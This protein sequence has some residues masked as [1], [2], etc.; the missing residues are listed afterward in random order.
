[1]RVVIAPD[2]FK[3]SMTS[4]DVCEAINVGLHKYKSSISVHSMP[5]ADGGEGTVD[6][7][8]RVMGGD[9]I[10]EEVN[11]PLGRKISSAY[12]WVPD[13]KT[14]I[15]ETAAASG[16]P[17]L[18]CNELNPLKA[19]TIGTGELIKFAL[20]RGAERIILG[21]GGSA[22]VDAGAGCFQALGVK[23]YN[24]IGEELNMNGK[25]LSQVADI[26]AT[27]FRQI[28][29]G[30]EWII[31]SDVSNPLLGERGA[32]H[33][34]GPQ[35]GVT[36]S[37]LKIFERGMENYANVMKNYTNKEVMDNRGSGAAGGFGFSLF[38]L[39]ED[40]YV[41]SGFDLIASLG[42][43][44]KQIKEANLVITG[45]GR[46]DSQTLYGKGPIGVARLAKKHGVPCIA[47]AG[48]IEGELSGAKDEG[49][50]VIFPIVNRPMTLDE[51]I[52]RGPQLL[53]EAAQRFMEVYNLN[54]KDV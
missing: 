18:M 23:F 37:Q 48:V 21:L 32:V 27:T 24:S 33:V 28:S 43:L 38:S 35:K 54:H 47:F 22:T 3:G 25:A 31:A 6:A 41:E 26:D 12:G 53:Q 34:F 17:R 42:N 44:E 19:S 9:K 4:A 8:V 39:I 2:S 14:A 30:V 7:I 13:S 5:I 36:S 50:L 15:I 46:V 51:A 49:M 52:A 29:D 20:D 40:Y 11:D 10:Y 45:E 16:L 1:M